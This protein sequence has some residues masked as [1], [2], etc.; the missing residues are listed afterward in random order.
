VRAS[1]SSLAKT[2]M[3]VVWSFFSVF[4]LFIFFC[5]LSP[6]QNDGRSGGRS[7]HSSPGQGMFVIFFFS[8]FHFFFFIKV[9]LA[10]LYALR[11]EDH[12]QEVGFIYLLFCVFV[13]MFFLFFLLL[14]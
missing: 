9:R 4:F 13:L 1:K 11:Y 7:R 2:I 10:M 14:Y 5:F 8:F 6:S 3:Q 12:K